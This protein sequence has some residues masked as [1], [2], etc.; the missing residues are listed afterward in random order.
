MKLFVVLCL[1]LTI[2]ICIFIEP[3][4]RG[5]TVAA[6]TNPENT[7]TRCLEGYRWRRGRIFWNQPMVF[8]VQQNAI[9]NQP[10][11]PNVYYIENVEG[12]RQT[13]Q[14][15]DT[16]V[17]PGSNNILAFTLDYNNQTIGEWSQII[18]ITGFADGRDHR[19]LAVW[20]CPNQNTLHIRTATQGNSNNSISDC[21]R[22]YPLVPG[23]NRVVIIGYTDTS[24]Q[25]N[26]AYYQ[27]YL[28]YNN[29]Q[30]MTPNPV[31]L[32]PQTDQNGNLYSNYNNSPVYIYSGF[33]YKH[34]TEVGSGNR[35]YDV[36]FVNSCRS[37]YS[38]DDDN[39]ILNAVKSS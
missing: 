39:K 35:V 25:I 14:L 26:G 23:I 5:I 17:I 24:R 29:K 11:E 32:P 12:G 9:N 20:V 37:K 3:L 38:L 30:L 22:N 10:D 28:V 33:G 19:Y 15:P 2:L 21:D 13:N 31:Q 8:G 34:I 4:Y 16:Q 6:G 1:I 36:L 7:K 27:Y 18:G